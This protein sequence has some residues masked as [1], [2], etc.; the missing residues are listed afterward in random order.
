MEIL[1]VHGAG[2]WE[3]DQPLAEELH[4]HLGVP[5]SAPRF[6]DEDMSA[7]AWRSELERQLSGLGP[8]LVIVGHSFGASMAL[9]HLTEEFTGSPPQGL[10]LLAMPFWGSEGWQAEYSLPADAELPTG[11][12]VWLHHCR[13]DDVVPFDHLDR[14]AAR[15]PQAQVRRHGSG[16]HQF[17]GRMAA[18]AEDVSAVNG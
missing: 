11:F 12:P 6:P 7:A 1:F 5:V 10:A 3:D 18:V 17:E 16:G 15:L 9:L 4:V 8:E 13:D 2:G 14:H